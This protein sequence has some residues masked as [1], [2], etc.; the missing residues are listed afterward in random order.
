MA[1]RVTCIFCRQTLSAPDS[2]AGKQARCPTCKRIIQV[3]VMCTMRPNRVP[4]G[5]LLDELI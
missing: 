1:I 3:P 4:N 2:H 5:S